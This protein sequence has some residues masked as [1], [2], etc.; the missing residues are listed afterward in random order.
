MFPWYDSGD[1]GE[2]VEGR[3]WSKSVLGKK[4]S[5]FR[6]LPLACFD[7]KQDA[8]RDQFRRGYSDPAIGL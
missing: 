5:Y 7:E 8:A 4:F 3:H 2:V 1:P 6:G